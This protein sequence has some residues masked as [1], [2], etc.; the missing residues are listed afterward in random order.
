MRLNRHFVFG[1]LTGAVVAASCAAFGVGSLIAETAASAAYIVIE[2]G[3]L[4]GE[5]NPR[6]A[7]MVAST[8]APFKGRIVAQDASPVALA[9]SE[10]PKDAPNVGISIVAFDN[11]TDL[12][13]W[14]NSPFQ[15][16]LFQSREIVSKSRVFSVEGR[17]PF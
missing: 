10:P 13:A 1:V 5:A 14:W 7:E 12:K 17:K 2:T 9:A 16:A 15:K 6:Y 3:D 11:L 4:K 8:L